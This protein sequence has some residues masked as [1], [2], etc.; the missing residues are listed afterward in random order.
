ME[1]IWAPWRME[2]IRM[3]KP[4]GCILCEKPAQDSDMENYILHRGSKNFVI[5]NTYPYN[6]GHLLIAPYRHLGGLDEL[7]DEER[8]EN[9]AIVCRCLE[10]LR[11]AFHPDGFNIGINMGRVA[12]AGIDKHVHT[13]IVPRWQG[14]ANF[15][16]V[17]SNVRVIPEAL[18]ETFEKLKGGF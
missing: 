1:Q 17:I 13:H 11:E 7:N 10:L 14:D 15:M 3:E 16:P 9:F 2:Y 5:L 18:A 8:N 6:P 4:E 12:G